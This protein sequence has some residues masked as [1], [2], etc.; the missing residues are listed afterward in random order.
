MPLFALLFAGI[1]AVASIAGTFIQADAAKKQSE[2][3]ARTEA[4]RQQQVALESARQRRQTIRNTLKA[5]SLALVAG[6]SD[7]ASLGSG[8]A[9]GLSQISNHNSENIL[10]VNQAQSIS[11]DIFGQNA[12]IARQGGIAAFGGGLTS[13]GQTISGLKVG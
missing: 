5:R 3:S 11:T 6:A 10:G 9:G 13:L 4:L 12:E 7:G 8:L 2:A 1:G